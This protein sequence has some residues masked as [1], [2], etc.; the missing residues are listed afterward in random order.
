[1]CGIVYPLPRMDIVKGKGGNGRVSKHCI[2][3]ID[4]AVK[5]VSERA[6]MIG[7]YR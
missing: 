6:I 4:Y 5:E 3:N 2:N 1:M 7:V